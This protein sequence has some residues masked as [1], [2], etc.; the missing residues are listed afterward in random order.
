MAQFANGILVSVDY[1]TPLSGAPTYV[2]I[3]EIVEGDISGV[4]TKMI[5][6]TVHGDSYNTYIA[7]LKEPGDA[8]LKLKFG[9]KNAQHQGRITRKGNS[10]FSSLTASWCP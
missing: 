5:D 4:T 7:G 9:T 2:A 6:A 8:T 3:G 10:W 1:S